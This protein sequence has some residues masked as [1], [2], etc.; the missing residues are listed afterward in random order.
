VTL[1]QDI[2]RTVGFQLFAL[3]AGVATNV[4]VARSIGPE[5]KGLLSFLSYLLYIAI[6]LGGLGLQVAAI[7]QIGKRRFPPGTV[8]ATQVL[9]GIGAGL[10][11]AL[12]LALFLPIYRGRMTLAPVLLLPFLIVVVFSLVRLNLSGVL[13]GMGRIQASNWVEATP[14]AFWLPA[15]FLVLGVCKGGSTAAGLAWMA[16]QVVAPLAALLW[17]MRRISVS[18][19]AD[20]ACIRDSLRFGS[21][22]YLANLAWSL[23]LRSDGLI[24]AYLGGAAPV[25]IYSVSVLLAELLW[26]PPR[27]INLALNPRLAS[28]TQEE[29]MALSLRATRT[30]VWCVAGI[31]VLVAL[32]G[33]PLLRLTFGTSF[34]ASY[35]PLLLLLP[36]VLMGSICSPL[37]LYF[38]QQCGRPLINAVITAPALIVN[39]ALNLLWIPRY[40]PSAAAAS[41]SI[42]YALVAV[43]LVLRIRREPGFSWVRLLWPRREDLDLLRDVVAKVKGA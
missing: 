6:N 30:G 24:L 34:L 18:W 36:G 20:R 25:G 21:G 2:V 19:T 32:L 29:A 9:L 12:L 41:S 38:T 31:S 3:G 16:A 43:L 27:A 35:A 14:T 17:V 23:L 39:V 26:Y 40:G 22:A 4:V 42:A 1:R 37:S 7:H 8:T 15:A 13:I 33:R 5:G 11:C 28:G 10:L